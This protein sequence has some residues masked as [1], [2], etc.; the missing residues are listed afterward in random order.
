[1]PRS[2]QARA[3]QL[4][5]LCSRAREPHLLSPPAATAEGRAP[6]SP[7]STTG[8]ARA[9]ALKLESGPHWLQLERSPRSREDPAGPKTNE[10]R[11]RPEPQGS[12]GG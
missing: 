8:E 10:I 7:C 4:L 9:R 6:Y 3:P 2:N 5:S 12:R 1:M 11:I